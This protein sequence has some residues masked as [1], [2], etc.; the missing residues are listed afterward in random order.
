MNVSA[1]P[2]KVCSIETGGQSDTYQGHT[3][4]NNKHVESIG[5]KITL[6]FAGSCAGATSTFLNPA[7]QFNVPPIGISQTFQP[8]AATWVVRNTMRR[9]LLFSPYIIITRARRCKYTT[10]MI[11]R[12][13]RAV[14]WINRGDESRGRL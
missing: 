11:V 8:A 1:A 12:G 3:D 4:T 13:T 7:I 10:I 14:R 5:V 6:G 9:H 2:F